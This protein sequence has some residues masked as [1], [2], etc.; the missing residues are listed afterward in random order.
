MKYVW[1]DVPDGT[2]SWVP[3]TIC[4]GDYPAL[5]HDSKVLSTRAVS[6]RSDELTC[7]LQ[8]RVIINTKHNPHVVQCPHAIQMSSQMDKSADNWST[9]ERTIEPTRA[10]GVWPNSSEAH[11]DTLCR[12]LFEHQSIIVNISWGMSLFLLIENENNWLHSLNTPIDLSD[13]RGLSNCTQSAVSI[14]NMKWFRNK[15]V[16]SI[17]IDANSA[18]TGQVKY[19]TSQDTSWSD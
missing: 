18:S 8:R 5:H 17:S 11:R 13:M 15:A 14:D 2:Y 6:R 12:V 9:V 10:Q 3:S 19:F 7:N 1:H 4:V 16:R